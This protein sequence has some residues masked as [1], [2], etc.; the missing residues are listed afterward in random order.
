MIAEAPPV[1]PQQ[2]YTG[3][4]ML[5][6]QHS[7]DRFAEQQREAARGSVLD[8]ATHAAIS[9]P[10]TRYVVLHTVVGTAPQS[11]V[12]TA[13]QLG[14]TGEPSN[15]TPQKDVEA[16]LLRLCSMGAIRPLKAHEYEIADANGGKLPGVRYVGA[17]CPVGD[18]EPDLLT[19]AAIYRELAEKN[20]RIAAEEQAEKDRREE[21]R[22]LL[23][24]MA[25][26]NGRVRP[27]KEIAEQHMAEQ[28][29]ARAADL[30]SKMV[31]KIHHNASPNEQDIEAL[32]A[33]RAEQLVRE[34]LAAKAR[35]AAVPTSVPAPLSFWA[36]VRGWFK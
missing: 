1:T 5:T 29:E 12:R 27:V 20:A 4:D 9:D 2:G 21:E 14:I 35:K 15:P 34:M 22:Q 32:V 31:E 7:L 26:G 28:I 16:N 6:P 25:R 23:L 24:D 36:R 13:K 8:L 33:Q 3:S 11:T 18:I 10:D 19:Q 30:A 17:V